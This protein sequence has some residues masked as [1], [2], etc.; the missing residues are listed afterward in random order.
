[1]IGKSDPLADLVKLSN[2]VLRDEHAMEEKEEVLRRA[3]SFQND[4]AP[5]IVYDANYWLFGE[6]RE[7]IPP[8]YCGEAPTVL[9]EYQLDKI[10]GHLERYDD[11]YIPFLMPWYG[12]G[13]LASGFG[14][15]IK[16]QEGMDPAVHLPI[17][18]DVAMLRDLKKPEP[19]RDGLMRRVLDT[20][21]FM[22]HHTS[23]PIG[24]TDC[25]GPL[26]TACQIVGYDTISYWMYDHPEAVHELMTLVTDALIDWVGT[27]KAVAGQRKADDA[28]VLGVKIPAGFGGVWMSDDDSVLFGGDLY[29]EYVVPYN[30]RLLTSFGGGAIHYCGNANQHIDNY[31]ATKDLT[32][33]HNLNLDDLDGAALMRH[34]LAER[35]ICYITADFNVEETYIEEY[36][37]TLFRKLGTRGLIVVPYITPAIALRN[38]K[39]I[40]AALDPAAVGARIDRA[41]RTYN[42]PH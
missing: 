35:G 5:H 22:R 42:R 33:I 27:Q 7:K 2:R 18:N 16:F 1:M 3:F 31:L 26:T 32:A 19:E 38:G 20:I 34:A 28:Y 13:V 17:I 40:E 25:Q 15:E 36:Y 29:R 8:D 21:R 12:T 30:S 39:Y 14:V 6:T 23:L 24:V 41:I 37:E 10:A 9:V 4:E 11:V